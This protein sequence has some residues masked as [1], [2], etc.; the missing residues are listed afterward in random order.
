MQTDAAVGEV[1]AAIDDAGIADDTL[2]LFASDNG[3]SPEARPAA[4]ARQGH[5]VSGAYRGLK[6]DIWEGGHRVPCFVRLPGR[7]ASGTACDRLICLTDVMPAL[8]DLI[9]AALPDDAAEDGVSFLPALWGEPQPPRPPV[10]HHSAKGRFAIRDG[11]WKLCLCPGS[12]GW[13]QPTDGKAKQTG[14]PAVQL[15][16]LAADTAEQTN[17]VTARP[18]VVDRLT[19]TLEGFV[20]EGRSTPGP[21]R[22]NDRPVAFR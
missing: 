21:R 9:G 16:D 18:D 17:L 4:L 22:P 19:A 8:A 15:Y 11:R 12:G 14:M 3:C 10:V 2:V 5:R 7:A 20:T 13:S 1:L 6:S